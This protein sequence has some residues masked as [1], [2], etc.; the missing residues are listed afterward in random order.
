MIRKLAAAPV[1]IVA[2]AILA[3]YSA[4]GLRPASRSAE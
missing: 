1:S 4:A 2:A 3:V